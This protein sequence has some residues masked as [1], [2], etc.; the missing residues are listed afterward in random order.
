M[1]IRYV[2][3]KYNIVFHHIL[4][5]NCYSYVLKLTN[6]NNN[7]HLTVSYANKLSCRQY[8]QVSKLDIPPPKK[9][10]FTLQI[11]MWLLVFFFSLTQDKFDIVP[12]CA[13]ACV[14]F[15]YL[16]QFIPHPNEIPGYAPGNRPLQFT[17]TG[18]LV[19][20]L[21]TTHLLVFIST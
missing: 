9:N 11:F 16:P 4:T 10:Q 1:W 5:V 19:S 3:F 7:T 21:S 18:P 12:V 17:P 15:T 13:L 6:N 20:Y 2:M 8:L 14:P